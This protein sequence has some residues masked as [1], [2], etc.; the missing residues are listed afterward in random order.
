MQ[1][2]SPHTCVL[3]H[4]CAL[5]RVHTQAHTHTHIAYTHTHTHTDTYTFIRI[6]EAETLHERTEILTSH[7]KTK[8]ASYADMYTC[9]RPQR[10]STSLQKSQKRVTDKHTYNIRA[11]SL[12][13]S[14]SRAHTS[15]HTHMLHTH[16]QT[17]THSYVLRPLWMCMLTST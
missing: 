15:T 7:L 13:R 6:L 11:R 14:R 2:T 17:R 1:R 3:A 12:A 16:T 10:I 4:S 9:T 8:H 5:T